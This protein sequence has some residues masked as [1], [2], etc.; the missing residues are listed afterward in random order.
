[1]LSCNKQKNKPGKKGK[2][3]GER[4]GKK[5]KRKREMPH[6]VWPWPP[7]AGPP[8]LEESLMSSI[9]R[10]DHST[11]ARPFGVSCARREDGR[12]IESDVRLEVPK[13]G[14][15]SRLRDPMRQRS[16]TDRPE[17]SD[18]LEE[19]QRDQ[20]WLRL[21]GRGIVKP[22]REITNLGLSATPGATHA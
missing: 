7:T 10:V 5:K 15:R 21:P 9:I 4:G 3:G 20:V 19:V 12:E 18:A 22:Y 16:L 14:A 8:H 17:V 2:K 13:S 11:M 1:M 6:G